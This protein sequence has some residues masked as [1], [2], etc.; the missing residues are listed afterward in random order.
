MKYG[1]VDFAAF[2][3]GKC[4]LCGQRECLRQIT[5]YSRGFI[6][7]FPWGN[8]EVLVARFLCRKLK[9][10]VSLLPV[11]LAPYHRYTLRSILLAL[12]LFHAVWGDPSCTL[13]DVWSKLP[14]DSNVTVYLLRYWLGE[15]L[16]GLRRAHDHLCRWYDL[17]DI[18]SGVGL[19]GRLRELHSY[20]HTCKIRGPP[21]GN[22][23]V[24]DLATGYSRSTKCFLVGRTSQERKS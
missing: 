5:P 6:E 11:E 17:S 7:L 24:A 20:F 18:Q 19:S 10:T 12:L 14:L 4:P 9:L 21:D 1:E 3:V 13:E 23:A 8:G 22:A 16:R 2:V 15:V